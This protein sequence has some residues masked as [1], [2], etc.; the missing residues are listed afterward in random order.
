MG[1][2]CLNQPLDYE[3]AIETLMTLFG[4]D[5]VMATDELN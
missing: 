1:E 5:H 4:V 2:F 3:D